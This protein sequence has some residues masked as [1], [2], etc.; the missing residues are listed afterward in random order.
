MSIRSAFMVPH[1]PII[2]PEVGRGEERTIQKTIDAYD[3]VGRR[4]AA[5]HPD[6][7]IVLSPHAPI[8]YDYFQITDGSS[9]SGSM[10]RFRAPQVH[11]DMDIDVNLVS[12]IERAASEEHFPAGTRG[13]QSQLLDHGTMIPLYFIRKFY[14][15]FKL[16]RIG[17]S[18]LPLSSH[19]QFGRIIREAVDETDRDV[20]IIASGDLS[21]KF[22]SESPYGYD[23]AGPEYDQRL[24]NVM[25]RGAFS[26]LLD[27]DEDF[28]AKA[29]ECGHRSFT[30]LGGMLEGLPFHAEPLS[31]EG[32]FGIGYGVVCYRI[33]PVD[34]YVQL[35]RQSIESFVTT[36][37][38]LAVPEGLPRE[39]TE[40]AAG[41][42]V[43]I[44]EF[45]DLRGC[46]GTIAATRSCIAEE[47]IGNAISAAVR[48]PRF[49][50]I[51]PS[52]LPNLEISVDI[53]RPAEPVHSLDE[54]NV[55]RYGVIVTKGWQRGLLLPNL[56]GI[57]TPEKQVAI[58]KRKAG[59]SP[60]DDQVQLERFEVVRHR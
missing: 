29:S 49:D 20:V 22:S 34:P 3:E 15:D 11:F 7:V 43:S 52:E 60:D 39:M 6:T 25:G 51:Q 9:R 45:G 23:E 47:I 55:R 19:W 2:L 58:A 35:A 17:L 21:H 57:D 13:D 12:R 24:M 8:Y 53:L 54:L 33:D 36:H 40:N 48:D 50:P 27:F 44:H 26:E 10:S 46:I 14:T 32:P 4:V 37:T 56:E 18:G 28:L 5:L 41:A 16:V 38:K 1:P 59:I 42:F 30:I 31:H